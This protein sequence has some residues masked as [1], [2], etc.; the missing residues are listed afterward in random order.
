MSP[1]HVSL[2]LILDR[3]SS[4]TF[5]RTEEAVFG[6]HIPRSSSTS[7]DAYHAYQ[8]TVFTLAISLYERIKPL[9]P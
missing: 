2:Q 9:K 1:G 4:V 5:E 7:D 6:A 8:K 3:A